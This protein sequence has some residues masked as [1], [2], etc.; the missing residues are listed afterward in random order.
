MT[1]E[2][3]ITVSLFPPSPPE[4]SRHGM[5]Q[6][7]IFSM[8]N[9]FTAHFVFVT[10]GTEIVNKFGTNL[11]SGASSMFMGVVQCTAVFVTYILI[12]RKGRRFLLLISAAGCSMS[13]A[14]MVAYMYLSSHGIEMPLFHWTPVVCMASVIFMASIGILPLIFICMAESFPSKMR[15]FGMTFGNMSLNTF[16]FILV[17]FY[18]IMQETLGLQTC[19]MLFSIC[20]ALGTIYIALFVEE[21]KGK[22]L[23]ETKE[24]IEMTAIQNKLFTTE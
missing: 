9:V 21:T 16:T 3:S 10:Y 6:G 11:P 13:H 15:P 1:V 19:L 22:E 14:I 7:I 24:S 20:C 5:V 4:N 8:L 2:K 12:D 17:K 18:P 23:N